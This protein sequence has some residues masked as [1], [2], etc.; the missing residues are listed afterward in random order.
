MWVLVECVFHQIG[1]FLLDIKFV[2]IELV[3]VPFNDHGSGVSHVVIHIFQCLI[4][5]I[6]VISLFLLACL[7]AYWF[8]WYF[9]GTN[10]W[11]WA[12]LL[13]LTLK[14]LP[15]VQ[16]TC[17][18]P[19]GL[20]DPLEKGM[21]THSSILAWRIPWTEEPGRLQVWGHKE[22]DTTKQLTL[23]LSTFCFIFLCWLIIFNSLICALIFTISFLLLIWI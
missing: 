18:Q 13:T 22:V 4:L 5:V 23:S 20:E 17:V 9:Q 14:N 21:A 10:L 1:P 12:S 15:A 16:E 6:C 7:K 19:L 3:I 11:F 2:S 8:Y